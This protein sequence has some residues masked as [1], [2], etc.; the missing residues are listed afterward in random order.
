[1]NDEISA[2]S[3]HALAIE[4]LFGVDIRISADAD[5]LRRLSNTLDFSPVMEFELGDDS[6]AI[7][8]IVAKQQGIY[9]FEILYTGKDISHEEWIDSFRKRWRC[10][11][12]W[13]PDV[14]EIRIRAHRQFD[15]WVPLYIGKSRNI[16]GRIKEHIYHAFEKTTFSMKLKAQ[17]VLY[18]EKFKVSWIPLPVANYDMI[19]PAI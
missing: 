3:P 9:L 7:P 12:G 2:I 5:A 1:M 19:V 10:N 13:I 14:K 15:T 17:P 6:P 8:N 18:G 16:G 4:K 11:G